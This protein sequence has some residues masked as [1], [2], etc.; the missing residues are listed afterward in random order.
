[1]RFDLRASIRCNIEH[2]LAQMSDVPQ[3][4]ALF[5]QALHAEDLAAF[6]QLLAASTTNGQ[7]DAA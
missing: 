1:M 2:T 7:Q 4:E 5:Q 6:Q 3:L